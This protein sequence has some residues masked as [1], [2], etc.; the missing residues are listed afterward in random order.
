MLSC[1][2]NLK[3]SVTTAQ[4]GAFSS[5]ILFLGYRVPIHIAH[6][7]VPTLKMFLQQHSRY[8]QKIVTQIYL[9]CFFFKL[10]F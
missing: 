9:F 5:L 10:F 3:E 6:A 2:L 8:D 1:N 7:A 4:T